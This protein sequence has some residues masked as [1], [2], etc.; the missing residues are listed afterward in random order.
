[1]DMADS[2]VSTTFGI[3]MWGQSPAPWVRI[4]VALTA[5]PAHVYQWMANHWLQLCNILESW[6]R[7][8]LPAESLPLQKIT[9]VVCTTWYKNGLGYVGRMHSL[10]AYS[11]QSEC[12]TLGK[13]LTHPVG[14]AGPRGMAF[15]DA[16]EIVGARE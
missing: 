5:V 2:L 8:S 14:T 16:S 1:M 9:S 13:G 12:L 10:A 11:K 4:S 7:A 15:S 3:V 6:S